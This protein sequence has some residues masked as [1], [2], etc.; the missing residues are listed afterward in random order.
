L[1][2]IYTD[3]KHVIFYASDGEVRQEFSVLEPRARPAASRHRATNHAMC[4]G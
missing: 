2:G 1:V 4:C 3:P